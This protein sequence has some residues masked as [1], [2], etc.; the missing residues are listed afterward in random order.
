MWP[1]HIA[2]LREFAMQRV[3]QLRHFGLM[4]ALIPSF[5]LFWQRDELNDSATI[6]LCSLTVLPLLVAIFRPWWLE[7]AL[8]YWLKFGLLASRVI[9]PLVL[10][11]LYF[12]VITPF[13]LIS[14]IGKQRYQRKNSSWTKRLNQPGFD[15]Q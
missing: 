7:N 15:Q 3:K 12:L 6:V 1:E 8:F 13:G 4:C 10:R 2:I 11:I 14:R 9:N 5:I